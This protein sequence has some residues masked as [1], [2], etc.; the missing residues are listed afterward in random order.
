MDPRISRAI[1]RLALSLVITIWLLTGSAVIVAQEETTAGQRLVDDL[2]GGGYVLLFRH[3]ITDLGQSD[4]DRENLENCATQRNLSRDGRE[5]SVAIGRAFQRLGLPVGR[6]L[7]SPYCRT[8]D[9][10]RL[11]FGAA[12]P[13]ADLTSQLSEP[14]PGGRQ[15]LTDALGSL[16][17]SPPEPGVNTVLVTHVLNITD[18]VRFEIEEGEAIVVRPDGAGSFTIVARVMSE[19]WD[20]LDAPG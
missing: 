6:V 8:L 10:A 13:S 2:R 16:L 20:T 15:R 3:A 5:Q 14:G 1:G 12:E 18:V 9:T 11:A 19:V 7:A 4:S 17:A